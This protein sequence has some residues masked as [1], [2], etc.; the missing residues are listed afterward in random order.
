MIGKFH[1]RY[2][3]ASFYWTNCFI[4]FTIPVG[5]LRTFSKTNSTEDS[6][7][8]AD[9]VGYCDERSSQTFQSPRCYYSILAVLTLSV[10]K[11]KR[12]G[13]QKWQFFFA[14]FTVI[15]QIYKIF[16]NM[17]NYNKKNIMRMKQCIYVGLMAVIQSMRLVKIMPSSRMSRHDG[18]F[19]KRIA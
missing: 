4:N 3:I 6:P 17:K 14:K 16:N 10:R 11:F 13:P 9:I 8:L 19:F 15:K 18:S 7:A 2:V 12:L 1:F 5:K